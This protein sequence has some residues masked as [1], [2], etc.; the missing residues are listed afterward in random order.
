MAFTKHTQS[1]DYKV[2][3]DEERDAIRRV[4]GNRSVDQLEEAEKDRLRKEM[5]Q[6][7]QS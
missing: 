3:N 6:A 1:D 7:R 4:A 5:E 2:V